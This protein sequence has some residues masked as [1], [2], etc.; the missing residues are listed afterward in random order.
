M[1][2]N[3]VNVIIVTRYF[4]QT[5][6]KQNSKFQPVVNENKISPIRPGFIRNGPFTSQIDSES[7]L[8]IFT[9]WLFQCPFTAYLTKRAGT[10]SI[11]D[12]ICWKN[13]RSNLLGNH[14]F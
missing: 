10:S 13:F 4:F 6:S 3:K 11:H 2:L 14:V 7:M 5:H 1:K 8:E 9:Q 12:E